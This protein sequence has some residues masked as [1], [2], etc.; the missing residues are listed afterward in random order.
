MPVFVNE[1]HTNFSAETAEAR[2]F[3]GLENIFTLSHFRIFEIFEIFLCGKTVRVFAI[4]LLVNFF[5]EIFRTRLS[6]NLAN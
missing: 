1:V 2:K 4:H 6:A 3:S 5:H